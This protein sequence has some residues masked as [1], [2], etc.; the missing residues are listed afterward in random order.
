MAM[1]CILCD[2]LIKSPRR[3]LTGFEV[4]ADQAILVNVDQAI[5]FFSCSSISFLRRALERGDAV[6]SELAGDFCFDQLLFDAAVDV[7]FLQG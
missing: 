3:T 2:G 7:Y 6:P 5:D 4:T 1:G